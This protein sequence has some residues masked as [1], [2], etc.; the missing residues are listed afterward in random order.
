MRIKR[1]D[2]KKYAQLHGILSEMHQLDYTKCLK[3]GTLR[4]QMII[5]D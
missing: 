5:G 2:T 4:T 1:E 3:H